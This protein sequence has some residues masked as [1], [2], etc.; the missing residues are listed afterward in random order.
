VMEE[1][2]NIKVEKEQVIHSF[3]CNKCKQFIKKSEEYEDCYVEE[4]D[5]LDLDIYIDDKWYKNKKYYC[6]KCEKAIKKELIEKL[7]SLDFEKE[8]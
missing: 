5:K 3:Y 2:E 6:K 8:R 1:I 4:P 7:I